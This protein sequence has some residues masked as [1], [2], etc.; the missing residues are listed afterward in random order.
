[1]PCTTE[2]VDPHDPDEIAR[3]ARIQ[4][5]HA[6]VTVASTPWLDGVIE[7]VDALLASRA[8]IVRAELRRRGEGA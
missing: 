4:P 2:T 1:M 8:A 6:Y 7:M 3:L 5:K